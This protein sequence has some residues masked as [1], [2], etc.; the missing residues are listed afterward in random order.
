MKSQTTQSNRDYNKDFR[1]RGRRRRFYY[2][3]GAEDVTVDQEMH[4]NLHAVAVIKSVIMRRTALIVY[5]N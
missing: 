4:Q 1:S 2:R 5:S 3:D